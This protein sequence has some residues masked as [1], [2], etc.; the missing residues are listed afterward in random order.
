MDSFFH[1]PLFF[2][3]CHQQKKICV[4]MHTQLLVL[5][6]VQELPE[7]QSA[8][9]AS[10]SQPTLHHLQPPYLS[11]IPTPRVY[12]SFKSVSLLPNQM[13]LY[14]LD[15]NTSALTT[16]HTMRPMSPNLF[17]CSPA[18][19]LPVPTVLDVPYPLPSLLALLCFLP[20]YSIQHATS[21]P[22]LVPHFR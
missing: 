14:F 1:F 11:L 15:L 3:P 7:P 5:P 13:P 4:L 9:G 16:N 22:H 21:L 2:L 17:Y 20:V 6:A 18:S 8:S 12:F 10:A 19:F